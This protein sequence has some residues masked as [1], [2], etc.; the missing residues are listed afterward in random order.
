MTHLKKHPFPLLLLTLLTLYLWRG[1]LPPGGWVLGE[2]YDMRGAYL[3]WHSQLKTAVLS[4][5]LPLWDPAQFSGYPFLANPQIGLFYPPAWLM[6]LLPVQIGV[7][8]YALFH[9]WV[10]GYGLFRLVRHLGGDWVG[11]A[12]AAL[13]FTF[14]AFFTTRMWEGHLVPIATHAWVPWLLLATSWSLQK[15]TWPSAVLASL[16]FALAIL[17]G[18]TTT[19]IYVGL[20]WGAFLLYQLALIPRDWWLVVR[21]AAVIGGMGFL[22]AAVQILPLA[23]FTTASSRVVEESYEFATRFSLPPAHLITIFLPEYFGEPTRAG[24]WSVP[25]FVELSIYTGILP[26]LGLVL[27]L[28]RPTKLAWFYIALLTFGLLLAL[29]NYGFLYQ[30][31]YDLFPPFRLGRAPG[32]AAFLFTLAIAGLL[33]EAI[34]I[35]R[36]IPLEERRAQLAPLLRWSLSV[37]AVIGVAGLAATGAVFM[38]VHP[39]ETSGRLWHQLGGWAWAVAMWTIGGGLLWG[40]LTAAPSATRRRWGTAAGLLLLIVA[41][42]W[43]FGQKLVVQTPTHPEP[44]WVAMADTIG[45]TEARVLPWGVPVHWQNGAGQ[46]GLRS[47]F[48]Y[49]SLVLGDYEAFTNSVPDPRATQYDILGAEYVVATVPLDQFTEGEAGLTLLA[50]TGQGLVYQRPNALPIAR[51]VYEAEI[52]PEV[53]AAIFRVHQPDFSPAQTAVLPAPP[54]CQLGGMGSGTAE[55]LAHTATSWRIRT[56]SDTAALLVLSESAYPG[57]QVWVDGQAA[58]WQTAYGVIRAVCVPAGEHEITWEFSPRIFLWGGLFSLL[59][60]IVLWV[61]WRKHNAPA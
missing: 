30:L 47:V 58:E 53:D 27:A 14:S 56:E 40:Y 45:E 21:Q 52:I 17:A 35:W 34:T 11:S 10:A 2:G 41:D 20:A 3:L 19:L 39:T 54:A 23:E 29:G 43:L 15:K 32:R 42:L 18:H 28:R 4:G 59:G 8:F 37:G 25:T 7:S 51:L 22:L 12:V 33:G 9:F 48:G 31:I 36:R 13:A 5:Q 61:A 1:L 24:Y 16:P 26:L 55:I 46:V 38:S 50:D 6:V 49:N 60:L 44:F 57:W